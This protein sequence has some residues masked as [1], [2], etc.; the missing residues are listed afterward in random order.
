MRGFGK[1]FELPQAYF[2]VDVIMVVP[3]VVCIYGA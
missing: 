1:R 2:G 3:N